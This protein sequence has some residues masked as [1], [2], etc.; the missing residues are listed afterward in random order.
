MF[1]SDQKS[2]LHFRK[3]RTRTNPHQAIPNTRRQQFPRSCRSCD[4]LLHEYWRSAQKDQ[5]CKSRW[6]KNANTNTNTN[7]N[8]KLS[9][10]DNR[11]HIYVRWN[12]THPYL[13]CQRW[14]RQKDNNNFR[15]QNTITKQSIIQESC[16]I[17][18]R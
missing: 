1:G 17:A 13:D 3:Q 8:T 5:S 12:Q 11:Y 6:E 2:R 15:H 16:W 18:Q 7:S 9:H 4:D 14:V 10:E